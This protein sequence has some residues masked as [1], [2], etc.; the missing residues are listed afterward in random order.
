MIKQL[1]PPVALDNV[2]VIGFD[3]NSCLLHTVFHIYAGEPL[4]PNAQINM[5]SSVRRAVRYMELEG[6]LPPK[7]RWHI[8][9]G[10]VLH[11]PKK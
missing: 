5:K 2:E 4:L 8:N 3:I 6:F 7:M 11:P 9:T 1:N 10:V